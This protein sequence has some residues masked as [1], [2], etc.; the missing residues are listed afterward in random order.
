[1]TRFSKGPRSNFPLEIK[2]MGEAFVSGKVKD[3]KFRNPKSAIGNI[4]LISLQAIGYRLCQ[5]GLVRFFLTGP[6]LKETPSSAAEARII[7]KLLLA[8]TVRSSV[9]AIGI[10]EDLIRKFDFGSNCGLNRPNHLPVT[11]DGRLDRHE[12]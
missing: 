4:F 3:H 8:S 6:L 9:K 7:P 12:T 2:R 1:M 10:P 5:G 11:Q